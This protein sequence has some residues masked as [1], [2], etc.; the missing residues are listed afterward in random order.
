MAV[1][2]SADAIDYT[3]KLNNAVYA[4][5]STSPSENFKQLE[6]LLYTTAYHKDGFN[7]LPGESY[8][9]ILQDNPEDAKKL[10][11]AV[12]R[13]FEPIARRV[14]YLLNI[15]GE[16]AALKPN[17]I[18]TQMG[19][20]TYQ[21]RQ[22]L[23]TLD[24][25]IER[26]GLELSNDP[27]HVESAGG[28]IPY[29]FLGFGMP[30]EELKEVLTGRINDEVLLGDSA[31]AVQQSLENSPHSVSEKP[32]VK[33]E[34][35]DTNVEAEIPVKEDETFDI[36]LEA[37]MDKLQSDKKKAKNQAVRTVVKKAYENDIASNPDS[38][39]FEVG[40]NIVNM[41]RSTDTSISDN[42]KLLTK[43]I[44]DAKDVF[45]AQPFVEEGDE[46][47][48]GDT[49]FTVTED[50]QINVSV[51]NVQRTWYGGTT[52]KAKLY[53][54]LPEGNIKNYIRYLSLEHNKLKKAT[55]PLTV[56]ERRNIED[57]IDLPGISD[58]DTIRDIFKLA[59][60]DAQ[61]ILNPKKATKTTRDSL[62][63]VPTNNE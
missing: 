37:S 29:G 49:L 38:D 9:D 42:R 50:G 2:L 18:T 19:Q 53:N 30:K 59:L 28:R 25:L 32:K 58:S 40:M 41:S 34:D 39:P 52:L 45:V 63:G 20:D 7:D 6:H 13:R 60:N 48:V 27:D 44:V 51:P 10:H 36:T 4:G 23:G 5:F 57:L 31:E 8:K 3:D 43:A 24:S 47:T 14:S 22:I 16:P 35:I 61:T 46:V 33:T 26:G 54:D 21:T 15:Y 56:R 1:L 11:D 62:L 17:D 55:D 12:K